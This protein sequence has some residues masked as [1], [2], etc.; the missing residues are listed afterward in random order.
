MNRRSFLK[1]A[2]AA[3]AMIPFAGKVKAEKID[4]RKFDP[5][6]FDYDDILAIQIDQIDS[7]KPNMGLLLLYAQPGI[8]QKL[9]R[10]TVAEMVVKWAKS[11]SELYTFRVL[12][13][14]HPNGDVWLNCLIAQA[15]KPLVA[16]FFTEYPYRI[17]KEYRNAE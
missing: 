16:D 14:P 10:W 7:N 3:L 8:P 17:G 2:G 6:L 9:D 4:E 15:D 1:S 11:Y 12:H 5:Q 13:D